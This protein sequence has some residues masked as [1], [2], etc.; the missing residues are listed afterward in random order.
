MASRA[1]TGALLSSPSGHAGCFPA[2]NT[3]DKHNP[4]HALAR[5]GLSFSRREVG[6]LT[7]VVAVVE[8]R[9]RSGPVETCGASSGLAAEWELLCKSRNGKANA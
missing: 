1:P 9:G 4:M 3:R 8:T 6:W 2:A 5:E 7:G